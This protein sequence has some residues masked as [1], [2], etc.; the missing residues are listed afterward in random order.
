MEAQ[1]FVE[2]NGDSSEEVGSDGECSESEGAT[3]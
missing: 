1:G 3:A 2:R